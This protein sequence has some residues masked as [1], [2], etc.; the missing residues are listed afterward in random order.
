MGLLFYFYLV[1][2]VFVMASKCENCCKSVY[3]KEANFDYD[4][5][6]VKISGIYSYSNDSGFYLNHTFRY[7]GKKQQSYIIYNG[8][9]SGWEILWI[10][11][12]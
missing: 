6:K 11:Q 9:H 1:L 2:G 12:V 10:H 7:R 5:A 8:P 3:V 4:G